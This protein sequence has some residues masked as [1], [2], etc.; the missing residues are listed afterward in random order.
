[1]PRIGA[2]PATLLPKKT[3][4]TTGTQTA[5]PVTL[6]VYPSFCIAARIIRAIFNNLPKKKRFPADFFTSN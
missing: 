2:V 3:A 1:M 5:P 4:F 6:T